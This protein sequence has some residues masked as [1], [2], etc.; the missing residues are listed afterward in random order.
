[1]RAESSIVRLSTESGR[2]LPAR[3]GDRR[4]AYARS[5]GGLCRWVAPAVALPPSFLR[6]SFGD[7]P[8]VSGLQGLSRGGRVRDPQQERESLGGKRGPPFGNGSQSQPFGAVVEREPAA[9]I[10]I[11]EPGGPFR[12]RVPHAPRTPLGILELA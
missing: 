5:R 12:E 3:I 8:F 10:V 11:D 7:P 6:S 4:D 1:M 2:A 9:A